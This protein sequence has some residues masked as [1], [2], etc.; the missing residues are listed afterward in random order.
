MISRSFIYKR[1]LTTSAIYF[2]YGL[3]S[4]FVNA[5]IR[6]IGDSELTMLLYKISNLTLS[7]VNHSRL[8]NINTRSELVTEIETNSNSSI[9]ITG[10]SIIQV[11]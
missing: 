10:N 11:N 8:N 4:V 1:T 9:G 3:W 5:Y 6:I 7:I 2:P